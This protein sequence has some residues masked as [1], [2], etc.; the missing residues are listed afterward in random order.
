MTRGGTIVSIQADKDIN[1]DT[2]W[3]LKVEAY[4]GESEYIELSAA[5]GEDLRPTVGDRVYYINDEGDDTQVIALRVVDQSGTDKT[6]A[7]GEKEI[8]SVAGKI[9]KAKIRLEGDGTIRLNDGQDYAVAFNRLKTA[10]DELRAQLQAHT[11]TVM[12]SP[13]TVPIS[14]NPM[15]TAL[16]GD[17]TPAKVDKTRL[18]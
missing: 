14:T 2:V 18:L 10:I 1:G 12:A 8:Y 5:V 3:E 16:G 7:S 15:T 4:S 17:I 11:H 13:S 9:R 6:L